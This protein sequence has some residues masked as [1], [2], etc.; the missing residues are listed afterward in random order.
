MSNKETRAQKAERVADEA[1]AE[2]AEQAADDA[3]TDAEPVDSKE[4]AATWRDRAEA[5]RAG[6][7]ARNRTRLP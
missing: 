1:E 5:R 3:T 6:V 4:A 7:A 2:T